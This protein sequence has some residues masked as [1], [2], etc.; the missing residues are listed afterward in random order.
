[1]NEQEDALQRINTW[2]ERLEERTVELLQAWIP[3][4]LTSLQAVGAAHKYILLITH[5][6]ELRQHFTTE[7]S[8]DEERLWQIIAA[9]CED[10]EGEQSCSLVER[11]E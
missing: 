7:S 1:M 2:I 8:G 4:D 10:D 3:D 6:L 11:D 9:G 5:L